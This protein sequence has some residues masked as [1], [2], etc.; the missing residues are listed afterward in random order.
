MAHLLTLI[1]I[2][3][4]F[5][6]YGKLSLVI[7]RFFVI[8]TLFVGLSSAQK[9]GSS[10]FACDFED[11]TM[12]TMY[13]AVTVVKF[14]VAT[15][16]T[17]KDKIL[18]PEF[19][20]TLNT[21]LGHFLYWYRPNENLRIRLDGVVYTPTFQLQPNLC[22]N[23]AYYINS[24][25]TPDKLTALGVDMIGCAKGLIWS[26]T[27]IDSNGWQAVEVNL[28]QKTCMSM[29]NFFVSSNSSG[30][31]SVS[32]DD[33]LIYICTGPPSTAAISSSA[34]YIVLFLIGIFFSI[35]QF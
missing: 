15:G 8:L 17:L 29:L 21:S 16:E 13:N 32:M 2:E 26:V 12:C 28:P 25:S 31:V 35:Y 6:L 27:T 3:V 11:G 18:G 34:R 10:I 9:N 23:F 22:L 14:T 7:V 1:R 24:I 19:D 33:I 4:Y 5:I 20:H 30:G